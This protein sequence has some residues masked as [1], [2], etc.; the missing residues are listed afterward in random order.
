[1]TNLEKLYDMAY[2]EKV[3]ILY[4]SVAESK[5]MIA[6]D[7]EICLIALDRD[8]INSSSEERVCLMHELGHHQTDSFCN[9]K[10]TKDERARFEFRANRWAYINHLPFADI[11][12]MV[13]QGYCM[14]YE[15]AEELGFTV[16]FVRGA[17]EYYEQRG[18]RL[19][20]SDW[21]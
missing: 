18:L 13:D 9:V 5:S 12:K 10:S 21:A 17:V 20:G 6:R 4:T 19:R 11:Q 2:K 8:K 14:D 15:I 7:D 1:M 3:P 16:E